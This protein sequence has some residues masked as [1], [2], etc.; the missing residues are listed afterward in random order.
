M[1]GHQGKIIDIGNNCVSNSTLTSLNP[2]HE[3]WASQFNTEAAKDTSLRMHHNKNNIECPMDMALRRWT[4]HQ[5]CNMS[6]CLQP[7]H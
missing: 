2:I 7:M 5:G 6:R 4:H 1:K 3:G